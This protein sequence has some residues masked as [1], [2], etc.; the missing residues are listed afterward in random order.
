MCNRLKVINKQENERKILS[1]LGPCIKNVLLE[2]FCK[3]L[4]GVIAKFTMKMI[5][6]LGGSFLRKWV[7]NA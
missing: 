1:S 3:Y 6:G 4:R 2:N 5:I 7:N